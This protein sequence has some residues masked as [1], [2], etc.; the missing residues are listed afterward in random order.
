MMTDLLHSEYEVLRRSAAIFLSIHDI[1]KTPEIVES[2][3]RHHDE[4]FLAISILG[5]LALPHL[6]PFLQ[7]DTTRNHALYAI[8]MIGELEPEV[9]PSWLV[10]T[11]REYADKEEEAI[12]LLF[13]A[14]L[15]PQ[16]ERTRFF[17]TLDTVVADI[18]LTEFFGLYAAAVSFATTRTWGLQY[19]RTRLN[20]ILEEIRNGM[21]SSE[22]DLDMLLRI[23]GVAGRSAQ[24]EQRDVN[25]LKKTHVVLHSRRMKVYALGMTALNCVIRRRGRASFIERLY[26]SFILGTRFYGLEMSVLHW[27][28]EGKSGAHVTP[29]LL[30]AAQGIMTTFQVVEKFMDEEGSFLKHM[31]FLLSPQAVRYNPRGESYSRDILGDSILQR[32]DIPKLLDCAHTHH[33]NE[34]IQ[35]GAMGLL[36]RLGPADERVQM[37]LMNDLQSGSA[38][39]RFAAA[40]AIM[41]CA[42]QHGH[43][44]LAVQQCLQHEPSETVKDALESSLE[45]LQAFRPH[46]EC[47]G[48]HV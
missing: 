20:T 30:H 43:L 45:I 38:V 36:G 8:A 29:I 47:V 7:D 23:Y 5:K 27:C 31:L 6:F 17:Q 3:M 4:S 41:T 44:F 37:F 33:T 11:D 34:K 13:S 40:G 2:I 22:S 9:V 10:E 14:A 35:V 48:H 39:I 42:D 1:S 28:I 26:Y 46:K 19:V 18:D 24:F 32:E 25:L 16:R 21:D 15:S 12:T